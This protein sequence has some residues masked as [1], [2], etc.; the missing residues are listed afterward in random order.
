MLGFIS[1]ESAQKES[2]GVREISTVFLCKNKV[3]FIARTKYAIRVQEMIPAK[4][5]A[6]NR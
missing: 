1:R 3:F 5:N 4:Y 2:V 6:D